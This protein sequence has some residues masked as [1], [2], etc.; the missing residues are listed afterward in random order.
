[1]RAGFILCTGDS[2]CRR[3]VAGNGATAFVYRYEPAL[4]ATLQSGM[5]GGHRERNGIVMVLNMR[6]MWRCG[7]LAAGALA[8]CAISS[9]PAMAQSSQQ[10]IDSDLVKPEQNGVQTQL[11][12]T[13]PTAQGSYTSGDATQPVAP[14][15]QATPA[16]GMPPANPAHGATYHQD[17]LIGAA[18]GV[19]GTGAKG[20]R[21]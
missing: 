8:L 21:R 2:V 4:P 6:K 14:A 19:F 7:T 9:G 13:S 15:P 3:T 17:D 18:Q 11:P 5:E 16:Q 10:A 20:W 12:P 1:M